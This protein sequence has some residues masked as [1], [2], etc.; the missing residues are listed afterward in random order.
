[1]QVRAGRDLQ[2][3]LEGPRRQAIPAQLAAMD[4]LTARDEAAFDHVGDGTLRLREI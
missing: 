3:L 4:G 2:D 1:M